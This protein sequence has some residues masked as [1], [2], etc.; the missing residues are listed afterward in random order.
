MMHHGGSIRA[1]GG[2]GAVAGQ[3]AAPP[4]I[5][6]VL[7]G[8]TQTIR[9]WQG[10]STAEEFT[11]D[12][13][14]ALCA[15]GDAA[16]MED[17]APAKALLELDDVDGRGLITLRRDWLVAFLAAVRRALRTV[18]TVQALAPK[19]PLDCIDSDNASI[20][21]CIDVDSDPGSWERHLRH[22]APMREAPRA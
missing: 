20:S 17:Y 9:V 5:E 22:T 12:E 15:A 18:D 4:K 7:R 6:A 21:K 14:R 16:L 13:A 8:T 11:V 1:H 3:I 10:F 19:P 2:Q